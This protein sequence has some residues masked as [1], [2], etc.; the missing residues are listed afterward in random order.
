MNRFAKI[1][2]SVSVLLI[3]ALFVGWFQNTPIYKELAGSRLVVGSGGSLDVATGGE[4]DIESGGALKFAGTSMTASAAELN[5]LDGVTGGTVTASKVLVVDASRN[6]TTLNSLDSATITNASLIIESLN[7]LTIKL[8]DTDG[9]QFDNAAISSFAAAADTAGNDVYIETEDGGDDT[10]VDGAI[11][12]G[13]LSI[14]TG[15]AGA[16][17][18]DADGGAG[19][20]LT[21]VAG[22]GTAGGAHTSNNPDGGDGGDITIT[23]GNGGAAGGGSGVAGDPGS[24]TIGSGVL[25]LQTQTIDMSDAALTLT[26]NPGT[27]AGTTLSGNILYVDANSAG[28]ENLLLPPEADCTG[29]LLIIENTGGETINVQN[30]AGGAVVTLETANVAY[31]VCD[32][33][34]W[35]GSVGVQ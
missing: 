22:A 31:C 25:L 29:L 20:A 18:A 5:V 30:D 35:T 3:A 16:A 11:K 9:L 32:G 21:I 15:D 19:G 4:I 12:G 10:A 6:L 17:G 27:P 13:D 26:L 34:T 28:T 2:L 1:T 23:P 14:K 8:N 24:V 7:P 33:T